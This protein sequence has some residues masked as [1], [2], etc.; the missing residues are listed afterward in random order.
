MTTPATILNYSRFHAIV[1]ARPLHTHGPPVIPEG[2][3]RPPYEPWGSQFQTEKR[4]REYGDPGPSM[5]K[6]IMKRSS[7]DEGNSGREPT[8][9]YKDRETLLVALQE[10]FRQGPRVDFHGTYEI[11]DPGDT[12]KQQIQVVA[13]EI[14]KATGY[15]FTVK[16]HPQFIN[17]HKTRF[18]CSQ[19][20]AHRSKSSRAARKAQGSCYKPRTTST[21]ETMAKTRY[22]C[23]S[24]LLISSRDSPTPGIHIIT[25]RMHHHVK[26][27]PYIDTNLPPNVVKTIWENFGMAQSRSTTA[28]SSIEGDTSIG[29]SIN[30]FFTEEEEEE[31]SE[32]D[33]AS[34]GDTLESPDDDARKDPISNIPTLV[35]PYI[36]PQPARP[37]PPPS[38]SDDEKYRN[39]M[40][41]HIQNLRQFCDGLEYQLQFNDCRML[42]VLENEGRPFLD[43]VATCL[44]K[45]GRLVNPDNARVSHQSSTNTLQ[46][47]SGIHFGEMHHSRQYE[48]NLGVNPR[49]L[50]P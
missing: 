42:D 6:K 41:V 22:P 24:R 7:E 26:H 33:M 19:D 44:N 14:W 12:H 5:A 38:T 10:R 3:S 13:H 20:D 8:T 11:I 9:H 4:K 46:L 17:G 32:E 23:R 30:H 47:G 2:L 39:R 36:S 34:S 1:S 50:G 37:R 43:F 45:E 18:W 49:A 35:N 16:D 28:G 25:V 31:E 21:G 48:G 27:E 15:R 40:R 29:Q